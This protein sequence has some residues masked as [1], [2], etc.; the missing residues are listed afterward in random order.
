MARRA[1]PMAVLPEE[2]SMRVS[3]GFSRPSRSAASI[4]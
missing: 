2:F 3:P 1:R 4:M